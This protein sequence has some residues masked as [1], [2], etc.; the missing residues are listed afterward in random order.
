MKKHILTVIIGFCILSPVLG[1]DNAAKAKKILDNV[2][3]QTKSYST[4]KVNFTF[5][6]QSKDVGSEA[7]KTQGELLLKD[8]K[9]QL[10]L[11]G[12]TIYNNGSTVWTHMLEENEVIVS[13]VNENDAQSFNPAEMLTMYEDGFKYKFIQDRFE[14]GRALSLVDLYPENIEDS[15]YARIRLFVDTDKNH[16]YKIEYFAKDENVY[17]ITIN[18]FITN[19]NLPD[20]TFKFD[21]T[22]HTDAMI[23]DER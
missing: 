14:T 16:L 9:Y 22:K 13:N 3:E 10:T 20:S 18:K 21:S 23:I 5:T 6:H 7:N 4:I 1:Q 15:E 8:D 19:T 17:T 2:S 12:N 11:L